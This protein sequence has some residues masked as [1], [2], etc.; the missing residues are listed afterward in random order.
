MKR[1]FLISLVLLTLMACE[2]EKVLNDLN[3][4]ATQVLS[5]NGDYDSVIYLANQSLLRGLGSEHDYYSHYLLAYS[6]SR[7]KQYLTSFDSYL[8]A[9]RLI[10]ENKSFDEDRFRIL[11][12]LGRICKLHANYVQAIDYYKR[13]LEYVTD[14][15]RSGVL[16]NLGN[17][18]RMKMD[19]DNSSKY[20]LEA[21]TSAESTMNKARQIKIYTQLGVIY[22][23]L[24]DIEKAISYFE[25]VLQTATSDNSLHTKYANIVLNHLGNIYKEKGQFERAASFF[26]QALK[27]DIHE[28]LE[29]VVQM[30]LGDSFFKQGQFEDALVY[31]QLARSNYGNVEPVQEYFEIFRLL[32]LCSRQISDY[33]LG[34]QS[35]DRYYEESKKFMSNQKELLEKYS[36]AQLSARID[37]Q[38]MVDNF[39]GIVMQHR[40]AVIACTLGLAAFIYLFLWFRKK[41]R[42]EKNNLITLQQQLGKLGDQ[43]IMLARD[44]KH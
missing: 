29:F 13:S 33:E 20:Y 44:P 35:T 31:F 19:Y 16:Y 10:P 22:R 6:Y 32:E 2:E 36:A 42:K 24:G 15:D 38:D 7:K 30:D 18:F 27:N 8:E 25:N 5:N 28:S 9:L 37:Q 26:H 17:A 41:Y 34:N 12:N 14:L 4:Q 3:Q 1:L 23:D 21:L 39:E 40:Y 11:S 43:V